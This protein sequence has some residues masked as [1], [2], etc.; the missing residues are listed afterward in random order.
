[1][2][3]RKETT[4]N[5]ADSNVIRNRHGRIVVV[6]GV[7]ARCKMVVASVKRLTKEQSIPGPYGGLETH[8]LAFVHEIV[9]DMQ[10]IDPSYRYMDIIYALRKCVRE[11]MLETPGWG[12]YKLKKKS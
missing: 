10:E 4:F 5:A 9:K 12:T 7:H 1:M 8:S 2:A 11:G 6:N 3:F